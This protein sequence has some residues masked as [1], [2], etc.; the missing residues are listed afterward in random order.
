M[1]RARSLVADN[2]LVLCLEP[3]AGT[4]PLEELVA[5]AREARAEVQA[6]L[7]EHG[8][9]LLR[10]FG[11]TTP[12]ALQAV[13][14]ALDPSLSA[15]IEGNS[16]RTRL[17]GEVYTSTEYPAELP[18][19]L[20]NEMSYAHWW[21]RRLYFACAVAPGA[22]GE[23][24]ICDSRRV[25]AALPPDLR[26]RFEERGVRYT[27]NLAT[28][29]GLG[30]PWADTFETDDRAAV[31]AYLRRGEVEFTWRGDG[32]LRTSQ[33]RPAVRAHPETGEEVWFNQ[34]DQWHISNLPAASRELLEELVPEDERPLDARFGDGGAIDEADLD[35]VRATCAAEA[36]VFPWEEG[37]LVILDNML[38]AHGRRPY[39]GPR[40]IL[41]AMA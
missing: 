41:L 5:W 35:V 16:P 3:V 18:I 34:A 9:L 6:R 30:R 25:L 23:T 12:A 17:S 7:L 4:P 28:R 32:G 38:V 31:E 1:I 8:A 26:R 15:Y 10:G 20:H 21:P 19:S 40:R 13:S 14:Q 33:V 22:G 39:T 11:V 29:R 2:P 24:P 37:D 36:L 27:Q